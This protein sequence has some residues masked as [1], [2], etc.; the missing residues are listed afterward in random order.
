MNQDSYAQLMAK[1]DKIKKG[2]GW[3]LSTEEDLALGVMNLIS[4]EE[5]L[6]F[7]GEKTGKEEYFD[8]LKQVRESRKTLMKK[9]IPE[10]EGELW[11][12]CKHLLSASMRIMEV[13]TKLLD[14]G[15]KKEAREMFD[16]SYKTFNMFWAVRLKLIDLKGIKRIEKPLNM[17]DLMTK[18]IDCCKE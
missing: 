7:T 1:I 18:L 15:K 2:E 16:Q 14:S 12:V 11:C 9:M 13:G 4:I 17:D 8:L 10:Y 3:D 5:H 6:F